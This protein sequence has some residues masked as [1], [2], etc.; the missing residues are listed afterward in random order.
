[1]ISPDWTLLTPRRSLSIIVAA[2]AI[3]LLGCAEPQSQPAD[4]DGSAVVAS[5]RPLATSEPAYLQYESC[6]IDWSLVRSAKPELLA[7]G[8][9]AAPSTSAD[10]ARAPAGVSAREESIPFQAQS[11]DGRN[12]SLDDT[13]GA[14]TLLVFWAPW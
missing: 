5:L 2:F 1:M 12:L 8:G 7:R 13:L 9:A 3:L 11:L 4:A 10:T 14:P 6:P